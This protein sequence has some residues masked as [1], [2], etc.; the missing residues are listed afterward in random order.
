MPVLLIASLATILLGRTSPTIAPDVS[1]IMVR[2]WHGSITI[3]AERLDGDQ[4][5]WKPWL[6]TS[7]RAGR[8]WSRGS[9][10]LELLR[11]RRFGLWDNG[12]AADGYHTLWRNAYGNL[13]VQVVPNAS[14]LPTLDASAEIFQALP[15][16]WELSYGARRMDFG[17]R[18]VHL[19][20]AGAA[21]TIGVYM[22]RAHGTA[23]VPRDGSGSAASA[24]L[25]LRRS[26]A[27]PDDL[28]EGGVSAGREVVSTG[29][30]QATDIRPSSGGYLR[31]QRFLSE[32]FGVGATATYS[33]QRALP[34]RAGL[35]LSAVSRW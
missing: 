27:S 10:D 17:D 4:T 20:D 12:V 30:S 7:A 3:G 19:V 25:M 23:L 34:S 26:G 8:R 9:L 32:R 28:V 6:S 33:P 14:A 29:A 13:R 11:T 15:A 2:P 31:F 5:I 24:A 21:R 16:G 18:P 22:V 1:T 35:Q